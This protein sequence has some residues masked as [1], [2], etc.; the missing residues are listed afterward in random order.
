MNSKHSPPGG[1]PTVKTEPAYAF[2]FSVLP[3]KYQ[4]QVVPGLTKREY[5]AAA[6]LQA[7]LANPNEIA[8]DK[9]SEV[10]V[11]YADQMIEELSKEKKD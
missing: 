6:A 5:F 9:V 1:P 4:P 7:V 8:F 11:F 3:E 2:P 10:A